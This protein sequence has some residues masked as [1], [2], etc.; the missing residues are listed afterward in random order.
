MFLRGILGKRC[1]RKFTGGRC[2]DRTTNRE[3]GASGSS[4]AM[5][6]EKF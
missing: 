6:R 4:L 3:E 2:V 5:E 1:N